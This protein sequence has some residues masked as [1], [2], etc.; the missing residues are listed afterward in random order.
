MNSWHSLLPF[1][2][3]VIVAAYSGARF[4]PG[5]WYETLNKP[6]WTPPN[7]VFAPAWIILYAMIAIAGWLVWQSEGWG[8]ALLVWV[9]NIGFNAAWSW[10]MFGRR[11]I[12]TALLDAI[13]MLVT[14]AAFI[15][16]TWKTTPLAAILFLPYL[17]WVAFAT[18]LN[19]AILE[20]NRE[21]TSPPQ[22]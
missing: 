17:A 2:A 10:L 14:I 16:L 6:P 11:Q 4:M 19:F 13:A 9:A 20:R 18:A 1:L 12:K 5:A 15:L 7:W 8:A 21:E 22:P 3:T